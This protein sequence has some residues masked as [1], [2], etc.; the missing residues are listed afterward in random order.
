MNVAMTKRLAT[1]ALPVVSGALAAAVAFLVPTV[2]MPASAAPVSATS[3]SN[4]AGYGL[5]GSGFTGV[6]GTFTVPVPLSS[7]S[8]LEETAVWVGVDGLDNRDLLQAGILESGFAISSYRSAS[9]PPSAE[10][11]GLVCSGQAAVY[12]WWEDLPSAPVRVALPVKV[13]DSVTVSIFKMSPGWWALAVHDLTDQQSFLLAQ[14]YAG[15]QTSVEWVVEAPQI[16]GLFRDPV[17]FSAVHFRDLRAQGQARRLERFSLR[18]GP[19]F[20]SVPEQVAS[21]PQ[22][23]RE[24]FAVHLTVLRG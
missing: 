4:W 2:A 1:V 7:P 20:T 23:M 6:T 12:A 5:D 16:M 17:P 13:G 11:P 24:G 19:D 18:S 3:T 10:I 15:P 9:Y 21:T 22:L 14:P 8:C